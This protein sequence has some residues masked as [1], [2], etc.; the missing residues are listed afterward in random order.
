MICSPD[1]LLAEE[2]MQVIIVGCGKVNRNLQS[3]F[4]QRIDITLVDVIADK[5]NDSAKI[6]TL[7]ESSVY[8]ASI[9]ILMEAGVDTRRYSDRSYRF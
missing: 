1:R 6:S 8:G 5:I 4:R 9:N 3:S 2:I 7:W